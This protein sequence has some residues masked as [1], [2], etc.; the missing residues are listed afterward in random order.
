MDKIIN[1]L[2]WAVIAI[3]AF[4]LGWSLKAWHIASKLSKKA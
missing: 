2:I 3:V 1:V 4:V